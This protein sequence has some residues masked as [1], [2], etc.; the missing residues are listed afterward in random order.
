VI[1]FDKLKIVADISAIDIH[2]QSRFEVITKK[3][4]VTALKFYQ[5]LPF[6]LMIKV[7]YQNRE[8]VIEF[9]GKVL[10]RDYP[11]L[12][13]I[14][15]IGKCFE[16]IN[17]LGFCSLD[18]EAMMDADVVKCDVTKDVKIQDVSGLTQYVRNHISNYQQFLCRKMRNGNLVVEKNVVSRKTKKR[19]TIY[20]KEK[21]MHRAENEAFVEAN[22]LEGAFDGMCRFEINL[23]SKEQI[24]QTLHVHNTKLMTVLSAE[25][26]P[27][28]D[29]LNNVVQPESEV[30]IPD[31]KTYMMT[32]VLKD[33]DYDLERVEA[34]LRSFIHSKGTSIKNVMKP[35][36]ALMGQM[37]NN[38]GADLWQDARRKLM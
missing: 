23:D 35:Y 10:G 37:T 9:S 24:R 8:V 33:C 30:S 21:E 25:A 29:F 26:N 20:D 15:T 34:K 28:A 14:R 2:D 12:I 36:I 27:I 32:L 31:K 7:D 6:L 17:A 22:G 3:G 5:E 13:S 11:E 38:N 19:M 1:T 18:V 16:N 4:V